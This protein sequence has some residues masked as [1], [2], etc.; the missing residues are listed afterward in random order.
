MASR[1]ISELTAATALAAADYFPF[2]VAS[3]PT[4]QRITVANFCNNIPSNTLF[5]ANVTT[6]QRLVANVITASGNVDFNTTNYLNSNNL[7]I[8]KSNT[9]ASNTDVPGAGTIGLIWG[10]G[11][12]IYMQANATHLKRAALSDFS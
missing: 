7:I 3:G 9:P 10:D 6:Q 5:S 4:T 2:V 1:K 12:F 8:K 11:S